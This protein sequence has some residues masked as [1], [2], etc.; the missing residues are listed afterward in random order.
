MENHEA[1][2]QLKRVAKVYLICC[3]HLF[4]LANKGKVD[5]LTGKLLIQ[6]SFDS[7]FFY[8]KKKG[9]AQRDN[10]LGTF[11]HHSDFFFCFLSN[12]IINFLSDY[13]SFSSFWKVKPKFLFFLYVQRPLICYVSIW[14]N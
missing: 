1:E 6:F 13:V 14:T 10:T 12:G 11:L 3:F 2:N 5:G 9:E 4:R 8:S 7:S